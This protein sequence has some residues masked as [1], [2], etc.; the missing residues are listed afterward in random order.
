MTD[1]SLIEKALTDMAR[2]DFEGET[3]KV[4]WAGRRAAP[5]RLV[6]IKKPTPMA[7]WVELKNPHT[8]KTFPADSRERAQAREHKR[9]LGFGCRVFVIGNRDGL[10]WLSDWVLYG[11][12]HAPVAEL[13]EK[14]LM[15]QVEQE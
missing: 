14:C 11:S 4:Q 8:I 5:D 12:K 1:E 3:R 6:L 10:S 7:V 13:Y 9:M 2:L 15:Y